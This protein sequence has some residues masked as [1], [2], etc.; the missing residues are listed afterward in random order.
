MMTIRDTSGVRIQSICSIC[1]LLLVDQVVT[2]TT[3]GIKVYTNK[4]A[5]SASTQHASTEHW[6]RPCVC[7]DASYHPHDEHKHSLMLTD[8][9]PFC[10]PEPH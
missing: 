3:N 4:Y 10:G 2:A 9:T 1:C 7:A 5:C 8:L 6:R